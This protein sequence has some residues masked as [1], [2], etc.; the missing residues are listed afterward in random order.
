L[1]G[2]N[3]AKEAMLLHKGKGCVVLDFPA[4]ANKLRLRYAGSMEQKVFLSLPIGRLP[5]SPR[6]DLS[7]IYDAI[8][9]PASHL[10]R[11]TLCRS[12]R[13]KVSAWSTVVIDNMKTIE[14]AEATHGWDTLGFS[15]Q[16]AQQD[17]ADRRP[18]P[19]PQNHSGI[20]E[21][22]L[23]R[24]FQSVFDIPHERSTKGPRRHE[25]THRTH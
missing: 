14:Q 21:V 11:P 3:A 24:V 7:A 13:W 16:S 17:K 25:R 22:E 18:P 2:F 9:I 10:V 23:W 20:S 4:C 6:S 15:R 5:F 19:F 8:R 12:C 1:P